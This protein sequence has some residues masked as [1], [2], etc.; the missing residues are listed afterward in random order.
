MGGA[1]ALVVVGGWGG[2]ACMSS[3]FK[4]E[5]ACRGCHSQVEAVRCHGKPWRCYIE[6]LRSK[7]ERSL[8]EQKQEKTKEK[9][10]AVCCIGF[11][12]PVLFPAYVGTVLVCE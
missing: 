11:F 2:D 5:I 10:W 8:K 3:Q 12:A 7:N 1:E 9:N 6:L 4:E